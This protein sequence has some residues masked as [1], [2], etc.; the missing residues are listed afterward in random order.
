MSENA[1]DSEKPKGGYAIL[2]TRDALDNAERAF[3]EAW[4]WTYGEPTDA[5]DEGFVWRHDNVPGC[6]PVRCTHEMTLRICRSWQEIM[7]DVTGEG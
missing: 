1:E 5:E 7:D 3:I 6:G 4:G 2:E